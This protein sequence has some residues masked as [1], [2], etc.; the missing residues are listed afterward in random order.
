LGDFLELEVVLRPDQSEDEG[1]RIAEK[2]L[3]ELGIEKQELI[4]EAYVDLL[5]TASPVQSGHR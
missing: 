4:A 3:A 1:K 2:L 5:S